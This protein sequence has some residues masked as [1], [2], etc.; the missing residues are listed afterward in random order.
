MTLIIKILKFIKPLNDRYN[1]KTKNLI[2]KIPI[3]DKD[4][5]SSVPNHN[6][7]ISDLIIIST[8]IFFL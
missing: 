5:D 7:V 6:I 8:C 1:N 4:K 3:Q 2:E